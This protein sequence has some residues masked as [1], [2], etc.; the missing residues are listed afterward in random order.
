MSCPS[1][2][3][4]G[5]IMQAQAVFP[6]SQSVNHIFGA[7]KYYRHPLGNWTN[8]EGRG[9]EFRTGQ[10]VQYYNTRRQGMNP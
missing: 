5:K 2:N 4:C 6:K 8:A 1:M 9:F 3:G 10:A 7:K